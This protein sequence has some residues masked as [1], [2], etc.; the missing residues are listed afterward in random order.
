MGDNP[1]KSLGQHW[2]NDQQTLENIASYADINKQDYILEIGPG[3]GSLTSIISAQA[4]SVL[5]VEIDRDL[6]NMLKIKKHQDNLEF[7]NEDILKFDLTKLPKNYKLVANIPYYLTSHLI[8][9]L[10]DSTN[11]SKK[12]V[13][14]IQKEVAERISAGP[15][16]MST[17]SVVAQQYY[18]VEKKDIVPAKLFTPPPKIDS[19]IIVLSRRTS[20]V[21]ETKNEKALFRLIRVGFS[22]RRKTLENSLSNGLRQDKQKIREL[23]AES[24]LDASIRPQMLSLEDWGRLFKVF[25]SHNLI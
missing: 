14:L 25:E 2:L 23:I 11:P 13:L 7:V 8:R 12:I 9:L 5:A 24:S 4:G 3:L 18:Q 6:F 1:K 19:Q 15:G 16:S 20:P 10:V 17:L 22:A 21:I